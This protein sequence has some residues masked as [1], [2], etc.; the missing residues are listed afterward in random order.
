MGNRAQGSS[1]P[2]LDDTNL[3]SAMRRLAKVRDWSARKSLYLLIR[4]KVILLLDAITEERR[5][6]WVQS[7][8]TL[9]GVRGCALY[10][11]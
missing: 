11:R 7:I 4:S 1:V 3:I 9:G 6:G 10:Q 5:T 8:D 2:D